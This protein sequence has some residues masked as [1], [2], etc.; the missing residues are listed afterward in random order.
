MNMLRVLELSALSPLL[1]GEKSVPSVSL[2][3][4]D[5]DRNLRIYKCKLANSTPAHGP[6]SG[7]SGL[8]CLVAAP[9]FLPPSLPIPT[10]SSSAA[11]L[12]LVLGVMLKLS[13]K[14]LG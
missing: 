3:I 8:A 14:C 5:Q 4:F 6:S 12:S 2:V 10:S 1:H 9:G 11:D 13:H 7:S